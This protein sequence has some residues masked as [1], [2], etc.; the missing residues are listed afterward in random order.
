MPNVLE[1]NIA[2][3]VVANGSS[4]SY[5]SIFVQQLDCK[6]CSSCQSVRLSQSVF[7][8]QCHCRCTSMSAAVDVGRLPIEV[9]GR[10]RA[11]PKCGV[12]SA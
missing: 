11:A 1:I 8:C 5:L 12:A 10:G 7:Y 3:V 6:I 2:N 9:T 4:V